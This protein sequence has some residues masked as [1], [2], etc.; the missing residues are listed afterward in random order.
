MDNKRIGDFIN[1]I[2]PD[3]DDRIRAFLE[4]C[5]L[6]E[7]EREILFLRVIDGKTLREVGV[8]FGVTR[9]RVRQLE[10][11]AFR[12]LRGPLHRRQIEED[13]INL[14]IN[15]KREDL[16]REWEDF[17]EKLNL[18]DDET[19]EKIEEDYLEATSIRD[20]SLPTRSFNAL[21]R[22]GIKNLKDLSLYGDIKKIRNLGTKS[23]RDI[24]DRALEYGLELEDGSV[25]FVNPAT[26]DFKFSDRKFDEY[27][28]GT[29]GKDE[30]YPEEV[31]L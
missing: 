2:I 15:S 8:A 9:E 4:S 6:S 3:I 17:F 12:K 24:V 25:S 7:R 21:M 5:D 1:R 20:L 19:N 10:A 30:K 29:E 18:L 27:F 11:K 26:Q 13:I 31:K 16:F 14:S 23:Y 28:G 22:A